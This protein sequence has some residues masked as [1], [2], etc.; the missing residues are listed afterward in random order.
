MLMNK[1]YL[2]GAGERLPRHGDRIAGGG[3]D[4]ARRRHS[5]DQLRRWPSL[6]GYIA[7]QDRQSVGS[8][9]LRLDQNDRNLEGERRAVVGLQRRPQPGQFLAAERRWRDLDH[10]E[11]VGQARSGKEPRDKIGAGQTGQAEG[12]LAARNYRSLVHKLDRKT[13]QRFGLAIL[14]TVSRQEI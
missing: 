3:R 9:E 4:L 6:R 14:R 10:L 11:L 5:L 1:P 13:E 12:D 8:S 7:A 2:V